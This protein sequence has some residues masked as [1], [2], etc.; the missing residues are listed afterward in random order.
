MFQRILIII[1]VTIGLL[2]CGINLYAQKKDEKRMEASCYLGIGRAFYTA[3]K[4]TLS[5]FDVPCFSLGLEYFITPRISLQGEVHYLPNSSRAVVYSTDSL[6]YVN[7]EWI[8]EYLTIEGANYRLF[9]DISFLFYFN[10]PKTKKA[11]KIFLTGGLSAFFYDHAAYTI[12]IPSISKRYE[13]KRGELCLAVFYPIID[14]FGAGLKVKI[15]EDWSL[16]LLYKI[17]GFGREELRNVRLALG[18]SYRFK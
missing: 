1:G 6:N 13:I 9:G 3:D 18:L 16:R 7:G 14:T 8:T 2:C 5:E 12:I 11:V 10:I 15:K 17:H 4:L